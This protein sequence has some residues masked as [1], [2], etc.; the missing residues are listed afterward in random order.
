MGVSNCNDTEREKYY[1]NPQLLKC[2]KFDFSG[3]GG[4]ENNFDTEEECK[5]T[6]I[7]VEHGKYNKINAGNLWK[8]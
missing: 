8:L 3:C 5:K 6:C 4:N 7:Y 2:V 1:Y